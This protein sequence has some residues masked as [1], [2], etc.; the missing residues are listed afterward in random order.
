MPQIVV[1]L[2]YKQAVCHRK[3]VNNKH[4]NKAV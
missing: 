2:H 1:S 4:N 3:A